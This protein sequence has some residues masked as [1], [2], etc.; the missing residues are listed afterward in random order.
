MKRTDEIKEYWRNNPTEESKKV[1]EMFDISNVHARNLK[2]QSGVTH[3][4]AFESVQKIVS[5]QEKEIEKLKAII[6]TLMQ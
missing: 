6:R 2:N 3:A 4:T 5:Q 1:A